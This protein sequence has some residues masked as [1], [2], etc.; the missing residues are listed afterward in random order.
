[1]HFPSKSHLIIAPS[2]PSTYPFTKAYHR[3]QGAPETATAA[4]TAADQPLD[5][6]GQCLLQH[7][8]D[9]RQSG[10]ELLGCDTGHESRRK[11]CVEFVAKAKAGRTKDTGN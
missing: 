1:M 9:S 11:L 4:E 2:F 10:T 8:I 3:P 6:H 7:T 5:I